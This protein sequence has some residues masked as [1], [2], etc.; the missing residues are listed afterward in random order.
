MPCPP[1]V[2][3]R[4]RTEVSRSDGATA[5]ARGDAGDSGLQLAKATER[6]VAPDPVGLRVH[7]A[8]ATEDAHCVHQWH[9]MPEPTLAHGHERFPEDGALLGP[10]R[11]TAGPERVTILSCPS[12]SRVL[13]PRGCGWPP[14][15]DA[16]IPS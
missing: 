11:E 6:E 10:W 5:E 8:G 1:S 4:D 14:D 9:L 7:G 3:W 15:S 13:Q 12:M 16:R 2:V